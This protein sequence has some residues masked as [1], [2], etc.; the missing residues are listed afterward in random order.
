MPVHNFVLR[1]EQALNC[2]EEKHIFLTPFLGEK[3][4]SMQLQKK[5][6]IEILGGSFCCFTVQDDICR[7]Q[8]TEI[9]SHVIKKL[10]TFRFLYIKRRKI[11]KG[12]TLVKVQ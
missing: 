4:P 11:F 6:N 8:I 1:F 3:I 7:P 12:T 5:K 9:K 2:S 10:K